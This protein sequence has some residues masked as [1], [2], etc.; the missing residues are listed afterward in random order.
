MSNV[1]KFY[2]PNAA[3]DPDNVLEQAM[4][5]YSEVLIIGWDKDGNLDAR[6][7]LGLKDGSDVNW[8][9]DGF[10]HSLLSGDFMADDD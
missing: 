6:A 8:L 3:E 1:E 5:S 2:P 9:I 10:K 7:S 4:G